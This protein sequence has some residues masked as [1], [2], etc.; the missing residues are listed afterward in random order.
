MSTEF[1]PWA[2]AMDIGSQPQLSAFWRRRLAMIIQTSRSGLR[3]SQRVG[4][5][6]IGAAAL[7]WG[8]PTFRGSAASAEKAE[9]APGAVLAGPGSEGP[10][11]AGGEAPAPSVEGKAVEDFLSRVESRPPPHQGRAMLHSRDSEGYMIGLKLSGADLQKG[12]FPIIGGL[13]HLET[14]DLSGTKVSDD[15]LRHLMKLGRL[16]DL[17]LWETGV[18]G[19]GLVHLGALVRLEKLNLGSTKI[20]DES[21]RSLKGFAGLRCLELARTGIGDAGLAHLLELPRLETLKLAETRI[22]DAGLGRLKDLKNLSSLTLDK[23]GV[24]EAG[25]AS[26]AKLPRFAWMASPAQTAAELVRRL[27]SGDP[28]AVDAMVTIGLHFPDRGEFRLLKLS[29]PPQD[30]RDRERSRQRFHIEM[31]WTHEPEKLDETFYA[32][33]SVERASVWVHQM[34]IQE[35]P[36][37]R[38]PKEAKPGLDRKEKTAD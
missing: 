12:D 36:G 34:G 37:N 5:C 27:Q 24:T 23:T 25:I 20:T 19:S 33:F 28:A 29:S 8:L 35:K 32:D 6:L 17:N 14:L 26:L 11:V 31:H 15:D 21:L 16:R 22:T 4:L 3:I 2:T 9:R 13:S 1:G 7:T 30:A 10:S 38:P 18:T